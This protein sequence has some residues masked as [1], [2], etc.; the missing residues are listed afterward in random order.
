MLIATDTGYVESSQIVSISHPIK[1]TSKELLEKCKIT[2]VDGSI[3]YTIHDADDIIF[4][5]ATIIPASP[6]YQAI[7]TYDDPSRFGYYREVIIAWR[8]GADEYPT[9]VTIEGHR[10]AWATVLMPDGRICI[11]GESEFE[12]LEEWEK[13]ARATWE[14]TKCDA[15]ATGSATP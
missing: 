12:N 7:K 9:P 11:Q 8:I 3:S 10:A 14:A 2:M 1:R 5:S 15:L 6:G 4:S 13:S